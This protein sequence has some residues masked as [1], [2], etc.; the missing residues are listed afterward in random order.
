MPGFN[1]Q[2]FQRGYGLGSMFKKFFRWVIPI[3]K[4]NAIPII[5]YNKINSI[6]S[7]VSDGISKFHND[8]YDENKTIKES[9]NQRFNE[10]LNNIKKKLQLGGKRKS[11][12]NK[13]SKKFKNI[14]D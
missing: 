5:N 3:I 14:F 9:A 8:L 11:K 10:T 13:R 12:I 7:D 1:G 4:D 6:Q 2:I